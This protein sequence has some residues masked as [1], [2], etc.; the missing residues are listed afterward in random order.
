LH[1]FV[2]HSR[3][4]QEVILSPKDIVI[5]ATG[6][7][8]GK[9]LSGVIWMG[10]QM[11]HW[12]NPEDN[13]LV[14]SP[15]FPVLSQSTL[16]PF[17]TVMGH[18]GKLDKQQMCFRMNGGG[19]C[20]FRTGTN[21]DSVVG[22]PKVRAVLCDE[23][24][25][26]SLYFWE[27]IQ[28]RAA[29]NDAP[30]RIVTSPYSL[31]WLYKDFIR[32]WKKDPAS[33][34]HVHIVQATSKD[35]PHFSE[36]QYYLKQ[37]TMDP[38]RFNMMFGGQFDR[39]EGLVYQE[40]CENENQVDPF[41]LPLG[42]KV[43]GGVDW[44][45][46][47]PF[48]IVVVAVLPDGRC[49]QISETYQSGLTIEKKIEV[50]RRKAKVL[51]IEK[52]FCDP[53][54]P[55]DIASFNSAGLHAV[56]ADNN[57]RRGIDVVSEQVITRN[58]RIFRGTSPHTIDEIDTYHYKTPE[59]V[60]ADKDVTDKVD[61][62]VKQHD[63]LMDALRY[64]LIMIQSHRTNLTPFVPSE[65]AKVKK[66]IQDRDEELKQEKSIMWADNTERFH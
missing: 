3:P 50:A 39:M 31:N 26:Y 59:D 12:R 34:P 2:P 52:F 20:W 40:F 63:H 57:I 6:I 9:T 36:K 62:P 60:T 58:Y 54:S 16:P 33:L 14:T 66:P 43:Y 4:Q 17:L 11:H 65:Q 49:Y 38:R 21:P 32:P 45:Y 22:I 64:C 44:G 56:A 28:G 37:K 51:R 41:P 13:F 18:L 27:N 30:I 53:A 24:G 7:Q 47:N 23:S 19:T 29:A 1:E 42:T 5:A 46:T 15:S 8:W 48:A 55:D 10:F 35:N 25:L 61:L